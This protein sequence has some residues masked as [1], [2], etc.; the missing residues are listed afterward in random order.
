MDEQYFM[1]VFVACALSY[2]AEC[3]AR[4][5]KT[6]RMD[7]GGNPPP[8]LKG[9][10]ALYV[11]MEDLMKKIDQRE[12]VNARHFSPCVHAAMKADMSAPKAPQATLTI[13]AQKLLALAK[14]HSVDEEQPDSLKDAVLGYRIEAWARGK[15]SKDQ[16]VE[17]A[18]AAGRDEAWVEQRRSQ[19]VLRLTWKEEAPYWSAAQ[20]AAGEAQPAESEAEAEAGEDVEMEDTGCVD[21]V[22]EASEKPGEQPASSKGLGWR[23]MDPPEGRDGGAVSHAHILTN[24]AAQHTTEL[25]EQACGQQTGG[26]ASPVPT[27]GGVPA[28]S[29]QVPAKQAGN[30]PSSTQPGR[31]AAVAPTPS[32]KGAGTSRVDKP[33]PKAP[34]GGS[35]ATGSKGGEDKEGGRK[36]ERREDGDED[37]KARVEKQRKLRQPVDVSPAGTTLITVAVDTGLKKVTAAGRATSGGH[38][39]VA[40][41]VED[42]VVSLGTVAKE[43]LQAQQDDRQ[44]VAP[45]A[46]Q[47]PYAKAM[48]HRNGADLRMV[49]QDSIQ[50]L[51]DWKVSSEALQVSLQMERHARSQESLQVSTLQTQTKKLQAGLDAAQPREQRLRGERDT[52]VKQLA[53]ME[54][55]IA[56]KVTEVDELKLVI[57]EKEAEV[58]EAEQREEDAK[59]TLAKVMAAYVEQ[60]ATV[61]K[62]QEEATSHTEQ[63]HLQLTESSQLQLE[64]GQAQQT[65]DMIRHL[66]H[67]APALEAAAGVA[68]RAHTSVAAG[69]G[70]TSLAVTV[71]GAT[72]AI[73]PPAIASASGRPEG[74]RDGK[75][76]W[77]AT[78]AADLLCRRADEQEERDVAAALKA[79]RRE[80]QDKRK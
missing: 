53:R 10:Q 14:A 38:D 68:R 13:S 19:V 57:A 37:E 78:P 30:V 73:A 3:M 74:Q 66:A 36:R 15:Y 9:V 44:L 43:L 65:A 63:I 35:K 32:P 23:G 31:A 28:P 20:A 50:Q 41:A 60:Q 79:S 59:T 61:T 62:L 18:R 47:S 24:P 26:A 27:L 39:S 48:T 45:A 46:L 64:L 21:D 75:Q 8:K 40:A 12:P 58:E 55:A 2:L 70:P 54:R 72:P 34:A 6:K 49:C 7:T 4:G 25:A 67:L 51:C 1:F 71:A 33:K 17:W 76:G 5:A 77:Q 16:V 69:A 11:S 80:Q 56:G 52:A 42:M 29:V 22:G